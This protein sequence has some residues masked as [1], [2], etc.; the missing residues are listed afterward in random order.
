MASQLTRRTALSVE[1]ELTKSGGPRGRTHDQRKALGRQGVRT[2]ATEK[3]PRILFSVA[4][5]EAGGRKQGRGRTRG[6][7]RVY[8][9][10]N[11]EFIRKPRDSIRSINLVA[12]KKMLCFFC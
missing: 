5:Q 7:L 1:H 2:R 4:V 12:R 9:Y 10:W 11:F 6:T 8:L 3:N